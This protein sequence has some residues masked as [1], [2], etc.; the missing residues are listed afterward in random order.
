MK[1]VSEARGARGG[2]DTGASRSRAETERVV[3]RGGGTGAPRFHPRRRNARRG[4]FLPEKNTGGRD[5][6]LPNRPEGSHSTNL[7]SSSSS[8]PSLAPPSL[9]SLLCSACAATL[10][11]ALSSAPS[12]GA[13]IPREVCAS[14]PAN[15]PRARRSASVVAISATGRSCYARR[16]RQRATNAPFLGLRASRASFNPTSGAPDDRRETP[17]EVVPGEGCSV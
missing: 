11:S 6:T 16:R 1:R 2:K 17:G 5:L 7:V 15:L 12:A 13:M 8:L 9:P 14:I 3:E 10:G 4:V